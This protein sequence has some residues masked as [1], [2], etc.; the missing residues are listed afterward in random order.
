[1]LGFARVPVVQH[2]W[3]LPL[4]DS[5]HAIKSNTPQFF[6][7]I[8]SHH[9]LLPPPPLPPPP[10]PPLIRRVVACRGSPVRYHTGGV[11]RKVIHQPNNMNASTLFVLLQ[12]SDFCLAF[13]LGIV[14]K[15]HCTSNPRSIARGQ[16][17]RRWDAGDDDAANRTCENQR[18]WPSLLV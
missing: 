4:L 18:T 17:T 7:R 12:N 10:Y 8:L 6:L 9:G 5:E 2:R 11:V 13:S 16:T 1:M 15:P 14:V 3:T